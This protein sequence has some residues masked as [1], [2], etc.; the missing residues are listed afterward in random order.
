MNYQMF[1]Y[2]MNVNSFGEAMAYLTLV[3]QMNI[4]EEGVRREAARLMGSV[5]REVGVTRVEEESFLQRVFSAIRR[6]FSN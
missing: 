4:S 3:Y 1:F 2:E 6:V 5:L